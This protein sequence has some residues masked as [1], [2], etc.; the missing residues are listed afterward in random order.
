MQMIR[1]VIQG[2]TGYTAL[3]T[4]KLLVRHPQVRVTAVTSRE[5]DGRSVADVH[6]WLRS[7]I[8]LP[9]ENLDEKGI[10]SKAD[11]VFSCLP[12]GVTAGGM[13]RLL[14]TGVKVIDLSADYR[15]L[16]DATYHAW[17]GHAHE[18]PTRLGVTPYGLPELF[19]E[20]I[21]GAQLVAN[22]GCYPTSAL[23]PLAPLLQANLIQAH[24]IIVDSK[25]GVSGAGRTPS[26]TTHFP[27]C[28]ESLS[29]YGI[30]KHRHQPE[31]E[32]TLK[33]LGL[34]APILFTPHL[35]PMDRGILST[36]YVTP[37]SGVSE[38]EIK[39]CWRARYRAEPFIRIVDAA[40]GTK[41]VSDTN[42]CD[43]A[44]FRSKH[45]IVIVSALDN[46]IKGAAGAAVQN[47]NVMFG[48]QETLGLL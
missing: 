1:A 43:I 44:A 33:R 5:P 29:A 17:Y 3:E 36:I 9:L 22:P 21:R 35:V 34:D 13:P 15:L 40:P 11:C 47:M 28:N 32:Q 37:N 14:E 23:I 7:R 24:D 41:Q 12:H 27:E 26:M 31:I 20:K 46:L 6:P 48:L 4:L 16:D 10:A 42:F 19:R 39:E 38:Q 18:D 8:D 30:G 45:R 2:A 25:S